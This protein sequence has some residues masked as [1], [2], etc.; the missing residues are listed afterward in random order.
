MIISNYRVDR[1][2]ANDDDVVIVVNCPCCGKQSVFDVDKDVWRKGEIAYMNG[3]KI[4][5][6]WPTLSLSQRELLLTG[7]CDKCWNNM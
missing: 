6:A 4:Q 1:S 5:D 3:A 7:M 2:L